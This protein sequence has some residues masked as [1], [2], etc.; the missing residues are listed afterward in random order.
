[1]QTMNVSLTPELI[2][3]VQ[4][5]VE[6]GLYGNASEVIREAVRRMDDNAAKDPLLPGWTT[7]GLRKALAPGLAD[8][9]AGRVVKFSAARLNRELDKELGYARGKKH[10]RT[11]P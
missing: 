1:M 4:A 10:R 9:K 11:K 7:E 6:S 5:K 2:R 3:I 8:I